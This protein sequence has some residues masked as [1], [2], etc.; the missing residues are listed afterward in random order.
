MQYTNVQNGGNKQG[1]DEK[2]N[3]SQCCNNQTSLFIFVGYRQ[4]K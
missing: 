2:T 4:E 1:E 3:K